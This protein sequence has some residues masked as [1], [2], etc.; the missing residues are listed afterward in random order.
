MA[1]EF[2]IVSDTL[3]CCDLLELTLHTAFLQPQGSTSHVPRAPTQI[4]Q[5][6]QSTGTSTSIEEESGE[7]SRFGVDET[8]TFNPLPT[9]NRDLYYPVMIHPRPLG[10]HT[11]EFWASEYANSA[12]LTTGI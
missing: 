5:P 11:C 3:A 2:P 10:Y 4:R 1:L 12:N 7:E 9:L 8:G 6:Y